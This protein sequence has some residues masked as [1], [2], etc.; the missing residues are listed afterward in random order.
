MFNLLLVTSEGFVV[1]N[2]PPVITGLP[3]DGSNSLLDVTIPQTGGSLDYTV[4]QAY[5]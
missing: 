1:E 4:P 3:T 2:T 5:D